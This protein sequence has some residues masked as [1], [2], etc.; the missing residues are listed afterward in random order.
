MKKLK[1]TIEDTTDNDDIY[2]TTTPWW[3]NGKCLLL[4]CLNNTDLICTKKQKQEFATCDFEL[5]IAINCRFKEGSMCDE[6]V[7]RNENVNIYGRHT[8][9]E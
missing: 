4:G 9:E 8:Q 5:P 1:V 6:D 7:E 2:P 3:C